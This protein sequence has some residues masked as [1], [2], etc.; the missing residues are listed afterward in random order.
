MTRYYAPDFE[1]KILG[2]TMEADV[3]RSVVNLSYDNNLDQADMFQMTLNNADLRFTD[4]ALFDVG[5]NV[6][7]HMGYVN[8]LQPMML[9]EIASVSPS[10]PEG[11]APTITITG[12]DKSHRMR[13]NHKARS[14]KFSNASIIAS[15]IAAENLLIPVVDPT[16]LT[17]ESKTQNSGDMALL[18]ELAA[19]TFFEVYVHWNKL[20]F[21]A[22]RPQTEAVFL[23]WGKNLSSFSP[24]LS[25]SGQ[26]GLQCVRDYD[27]KLATTIVGLVPVV[28]VDTNLDN[29]IEKLGSTFVDQLSEF[30]LSCVTDETVDSFPEALAFAK[31]ILQEILEG[32]FEGHG[33]CI[34]IPELR[35][36]NIVNIAGIGKKF[37]GDYRLRK[38]THSIGGGGYQTTFEVTQK[39]SSTMLQLFRK[40]F[41]DSPSPNRRKKMDSAV[42]ATVINNVDSEGLG[43]VQLRYP[44]FS[45][46][47]IS[48]WAKVVQPDIGTYFMPNIGEDVWVTFEKGDFD[49]PVVTGSLWN[50]NNM[51]SETPTPDNFRKVIR[52]RLGHQIVWD[53]TPES[54]GISIETTNKAKLHLD[55]KGNVIIQAG[56]SGTIT[57]KSSGVALTVGATAVDVS[58]I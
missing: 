22:P 11:G 46:T 25:T 1:V 54:G 15:Q 30:G 7:I 53:D 31:S 14:F 19:R 2:L 41:E 38:V 12:Y 29:I 18:K 58:T 16:P 9:G 20:Y 5:K 40:V 42:V 26:V 51:P 13:H 17:F 57:L 43:R 45:D 24:R 3:K 34:G 4:S 37:S 55:A 39:S 27:Q 10:F 23:E 52:T 6:E 35:A 33:T 32:V 56:P 36:G 50:V 49:R 8:N 44:W 47:V 21:R 48:A 28:S